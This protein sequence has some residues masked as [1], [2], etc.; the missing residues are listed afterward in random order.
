M[1][2]ILQ[3]K[4]YYATV[5]FN[6]DDE[7]FHGKVLGINDV[8]SFEGTTVK[9]LKLAFEEAVDDYLET[10]K[11]L[12]KH[13]DKTYKGTFNVRISASL[14]RDAARYAAAKNMTLND[15]VKQAIN[16]VIHK[17]PDLNTSQVLVYLA[18]VLPALLAGFLMSCRTCCSLDFREYVLMGPA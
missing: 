10:C 12:G 2:D 1:N 5:H 11:E 13:P 16:F 6:A 3:Y 4:E 15:F 14:H 7:V 8:V 17:S 18:I 9:E